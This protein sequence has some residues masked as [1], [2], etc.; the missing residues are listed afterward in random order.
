MTNPFESRFNQK[1]HHF[2]P[3]LA[4]SL[5]TRFVRLDF[6]DYP[7]VIHAI[8][9]CTLEVINPYISLIIFRDGEPVVNHNQATTL[10]F[11]NNTFSSGAIRAVIGLVGKKVQTGHM[12]N[13]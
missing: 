12:G 9:L 5:V 4:K 10:S 11:C 3:L 2:K 13:S 1:I 6:G 7:V 8:S